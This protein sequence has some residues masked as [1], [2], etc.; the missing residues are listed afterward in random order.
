[1][2][3]RLGSRALGLLPALVLALLGGAFLTRRQSLWYDEL[4]TA[5]VAPVPFGELARAVLSGE[6]TTSYLVGVPPSYNAPYYA[7]AHLWLVLTRLP[8]NDVGLRL[9]SLIAAVA[10]VAVLTAA[11]S[12]LAGRAVGLT[13]GLVAA[14]NP[15]VVEFAVEARGYGLA[16]LATA[17]ASFGLARWLDGGRVW[18]YT[19]GATLTGLAHWFA[20]PVV[21]GLALAGLLLRR[22]Q[23][24]GL[25]ALTA[26]AAVPTLLLV[27]LTQLNGLGD[28]AIGPIPNVGAAVPA[29][30]VKAWAAG[31]L[32]LIVATVLAV[33]AGLWQGVRSGAPAR[34]TAVVGACWVGVPLLAV[35]L[36]Q[37]ARPV[38][39]PRYL[40]AALLGLSVLAALGTTRLPGRWRVIGAG[41]LVVLSLVAVADVYGRGVR[42]DARGVVA[43]VAER[44]RAGEPVVAVDRRAALALEHYAEREHPRLLPDLVVPPDDPP[45][46]GVETVWLVRESVRGRPLPSD[47]DDVLVAQGLRITDS[48]VL[49]GTIMD[50]V[51]QRWSR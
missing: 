26:L 25:L 13:A 11:A 8:A 51:V 49:P 2:A 32:P 21:A 14:T 12:R 1:M 42:E 6:G 16:M 7:V 30:A 9:L 39:V 19:A 15:L 24:L 40:L 27:G 44:Q 33:A 28:G 23:A 22:R 31:S 37:L 5:E 47:D 20:L 35:T 36:A 34:R 50:L 10:A 43:L 4:F 41:S 45:A 48:W 17:V 3:G 38:F 29:L 18:L 46:R